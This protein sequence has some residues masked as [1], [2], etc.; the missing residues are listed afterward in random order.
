MTQTAATPLISAIVSARKD[1]KFL[2][3][4][5]FGWLM[6]TRDWGKS[7]LIVVYNEHD[8]WNRELIEFYKGMHHVFGIK[9]V[10]ENKGL[11]RAG[12]HEYFHEGLKLA[13]GKWVIYFCEDHFITRKNWDGY[14]A[15]IVDAIDPE[16]IYVLTPK[17]DNVGPMNHIVSRGWIDALGGVIGRHGWIDSYLNDVRSGLP[18]DRV[19]LLNE[20]TFHDFT[21]DQP[22]PM[23]EAANQSVVSEKGAKLPPYKSD[24][25]RQLIKKD[26]ETLN[27][28]IVRGL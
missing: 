20:V 2:A 5:I 13:R 14:I 3:K 24:E 27:Q 10:A 9:F 16:K 28:K 17:F 22:N 11:G 4:F 25:V 8:T 1:S 12:L 19:I 6:N 7:E 26:I 18:K 23:S 21:H 15:Q